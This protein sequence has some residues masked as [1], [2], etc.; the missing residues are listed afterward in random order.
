[1]SSSCTVSSAATRRSLLA[2]TI[3]DGRSGA[4]RTSRVTARA[5]A[6]PATPVRRQTPSSG[7]AV[8]GRCRREGLDPR[9]SPV[10]VG[11]PGEHRDAP[12]AEAHEVCDRRSNSERMIGE[13]GG[14]GD[15]VESAIDEHGRQRSDRAREIVGPLRGDRE[16]QA[17]D[18]AGEE[19]R[20]GLLLADRVAVGV[21]EQKGVSV[22]LED[23]LD[24]LADGRKVRVA[25]VRDD[26]PDGA[27]LPGSDAARSRVGLVPEAGDGRG[28]PP[29][30]GGIDAVR[31]ARDARRS[32]EGD[33]CLGGHLTQRSNGFEP[34]LAT[35]PTLS[36]ASDEARAG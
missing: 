34:L 1:M 14:G 25:D 18:A 23:G 26:E 5:S 16:D 20:D 2:T 9:A 12:M 4:E 13:D 31:A 32:R 6:S 10:L 35:M 3:A 17:V 21:D 24:A 11:V 22:L 15:A 29:A 27:A 30:H 7:H 36:P 28:D 33:A 19:R 8:R